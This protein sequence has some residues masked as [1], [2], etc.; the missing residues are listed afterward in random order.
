MPR[1]H[2]RNQTTLC[3]LPDRVTRDLTLSSATA[4]AQVIRRAAGE[5]LRR[6]SLEHRLRLLGV[7]V[8]TLSSAGHDCETT[9]VQGELVFSTRVDEAAAETR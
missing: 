4:D 3:R 1:P 8:T 7:R 5:C 6:V 2:D 9:P